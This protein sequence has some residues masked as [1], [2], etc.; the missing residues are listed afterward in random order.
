[1]ERLASCG[2]RQRWEFLLLPQPRD[3]L[4]GER[5]ILCVSRR[6]HGTNWKH[7]V[8]L[9]SPPPFQGRGVS[10][11]ENLE[12]QNSYL[13]LSTLEFE[14]MLFFFHSFLSI[15]NLSTLNADNES[16]TWQI[17]LEIQMDFY[18]ET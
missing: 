12:R 10:D 18:S 5:N 1:M 14:S 4:L 16:S 15:G 17:G 7:R 11:K 3:Y 13:Q 8:S 9:A 2:G 6:P